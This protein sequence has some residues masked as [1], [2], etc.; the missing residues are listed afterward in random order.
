MIECLDVDLSHDKTQ[1][2][3]LRDNRDMD[4]IVS[5]DHPSRSVLFSS[6]TFVFFS[7]TFCQSPDRTLFDI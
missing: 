3:D 6:S 5:W 4:V 1:W 2:D 7:G